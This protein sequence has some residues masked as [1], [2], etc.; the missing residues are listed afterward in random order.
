MSE[1]NINKIVGDSFEELTIAEMTQV[2]GAGDVQV[3]S[4]L[5]CFAGSFALSVGIVKSLKG[6]C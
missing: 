3:E 1:I 2:H 5:L 6:N 4:T